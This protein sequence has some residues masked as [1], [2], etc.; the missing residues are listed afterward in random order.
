MININ[1]FQRGIMLFNLFHKHSWSKPQRQEDGLYMTCCECGERH[2]LQIYYDCE[3]GLVSLGT[4]NK[5]LVK[6]NRIVSADRSH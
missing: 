3:T 5:K 2:K 4:G 6:V 1:Q